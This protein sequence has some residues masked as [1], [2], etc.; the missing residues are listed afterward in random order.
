MSVLILH[1]RG[2]LKATPYD[3][4]L[5]NY[6]GKKLLLADPEH[7]ALVGEELPG[8]D[9]GYDH[10]EGIAGYEASG[11]VEARAL[12]LA[13]RHDVKYIIACQE[14]DLERAAQLREI[15]GLPGQTLPSVLPFRNKLLM[16]DTASAAGIDVAP[17][18]DVECAAD[19]LAFADRHGFPIVLKPRDGAG[20]I[21]VSIL[22]T[23]E[24]LDRFLA[25]DFALGGSFQSNLLVEG[26][27]EGP[28][29]HVDGLVVDGR[30]VYA[31]PSQY[32][33]A[34]IDYKDDLN[35]RMDVTLDADDPLTGRLI[36]FMDRVLEN[37]PAP[38]HFAFHAEIFHTPDDRLVL[39]EVACRTG[40][41]AQ[42]DIQRLMW[43]LDPTESWI[44]AQLGM[45]LARE[46]GSERLRPA[47]LTG[48]M[49]LMKRPGTVLSVP[50][51]APFPWVEKQTVFV[52]PGQVMKAASFSADFVA[53]Y[54]VT[55]PTRRQSVQRM[56]QLEEWFL[57][58]LSL[59]EA[60]GRA[61]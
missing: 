10:V 60:P 3:Q 21:G 59:A 15:L 45:P 27:V 14:Q 51:L 20:S 2:S 9:S 30:V 18:A 13:R 22:R 33:Y 58:K 23:R 32:L 1:H 7:L 36:D 11:R 61:A 24:E 40:G 4:W 57:G 42:R 35:A 8:R 46:I 34:L 48:Q 39:G 41:A 5:S 37:F 6:D 26:Y 56:K 50:G 16:K 19:I 49:V 44:Q 53:A 54:V 55:A 17:Y 28:M 31:W 29:C 12:E 25:S 47:T 43:G 38:Q 52:K